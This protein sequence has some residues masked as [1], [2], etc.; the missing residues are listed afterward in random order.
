MYIL[1][2]L[3]CWFVISVFLASYLGGILKKNSEYYK[4]YHD[5]EDED[6]NNG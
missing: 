4:P 2:A 1:L 6:N 3:V 5:D